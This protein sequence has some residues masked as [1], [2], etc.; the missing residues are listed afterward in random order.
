LGRYWWEVFVLWDRFACTHW[1]FALS[2]QAL[3][4][5]CYDQLVDDIWCRHHQ[6]YLSCFQNWIIKLILLILSF[7]LFFY[8]FF[9]SV[10]LLQFLHRPK[11]VLPL[12]ILLLTKFQDF[13]QLLKAIVQPVSSRSF[14]PIY[15]LIKNSSNTH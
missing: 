11:Q 10:L 12:R 3:M 15:K 1:F 5:I 9:S 6:K 7:L 14:A 13:P 4:S 8:L 2:S